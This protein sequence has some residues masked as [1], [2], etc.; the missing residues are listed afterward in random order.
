MKA[1]SIWASHHSKKA[2]TLIVIIE[3]AKNFIGF[4]IGHNFLPT[5][6]P[7]FIELAIL[8]IVF[9]ITFVQTTYQHQVLTLSK[10]AHR[11]LRLRSTAII[12]TSSLF[13][14]ILMGNHLK[15]LGYQINGV[16][17][18]NAAVS[19]VADSVQQSTTNEIKEKK[20]Q[21]RLF[22]K[23][24]AD[25]DPFG[26][27]RIGYVLLFVL[28]LVLTYFG[29]YLTC[30]IACS[31][32]GVLAVLALLLTLGVLSGGIYF[33]FK[34]F[35]KKVRPYSSMSKEERKK[36]RKKFFILW[37]VLSA[38]TALFI[39]IQSAVNS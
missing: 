24:T 32:Y 13:L 26:K 34:A 7:A 17:S 29:V 28:S 25:N 27:R 23:K 35:S 3:L 15:G 33:L 10:E 38:L 6:S 21:F 8:A 12:F 30:S 18:A 11:W 19:M 37:G 1:I 39:L 20:H 31:G 22:A 4:D 2:I 5:L 14:S 16:I 36:E 9:L